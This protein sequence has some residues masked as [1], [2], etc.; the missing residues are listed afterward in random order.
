MIPKILV[1]NGPNLNML[2]T[3]GPEVYGTET[4]AD[5]ESA[6]RARAGGHGCQ[7]ALE[8]LARILHVDQNQ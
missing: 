1:I 4:L 2:G 6:C 3:R 7:L 8:T 5:I